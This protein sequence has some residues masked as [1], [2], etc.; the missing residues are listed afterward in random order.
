MI[1]LKPYLPLFIALA[2]FSTFSFVKA[3]CRKDTVTN[4]TFTGSNKDITGRLIR[5]Y[6]IKNQVLLEYSQVWNNTSKKWEDDSKTEYVYDANFNLISETESQYNSSWEVSSKILYTYNS[7]N[8]L[9]EYIYQI[10]D[11]MG[12]LENSM[13]Y[14]NTVN[15][16]HKISV[17][18][19]YNWN[20]GSSDWDHASNRYSF[21]Y[22]GKN[23]LAIQTSEKWQ[24]GSNTWVFVD[25][26]TYSY[27]G[28]NNNTTY[29]Y[30]IWD[31]GSNAF[32]NWLKNNYTF[33]ASNLITQTLY[34]S[35][36]SGKWNDKSRR[37]YTYNS[38]NN[39]LE[40]NN[41][42]WSS[43]VWVNAKKTTWEYNGS[44]DNTATD[45]YASWSTDKYLY[46]DREEYACT[47]IEGVGIEKIN[48]INIDI[49]PNP[50]NGNILNMNTEAA[51]EY[52][53]VDINGQIISTGKLQAGT[54]S[55]NISSIQKSGLYFFKTNAGVVKVVIER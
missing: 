15:G 41:Q 25:K 47:H 44:N 21:T 1:K 31:E 17:Q 19:L 40:E 27:D 34:Q 42:N 53:L 10:S 4:Y 28:N 8:D 32:V 23:L 51:C 52:S 37:T 46:H 48:K 22:N 29:L 45:F 54:N 30:E 18:Q 6:N 33:N 20:T 9:I 24:T 38:N 2:I 12:N 50:A 3:E 55:I 5:Q 13:K 43:N 26:S 11:G 39:M 49:Y 36:G 14:S 7:S 16:N 35:W